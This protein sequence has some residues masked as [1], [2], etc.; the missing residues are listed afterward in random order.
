MRKSPVSKN[1]IIASNQY[2]IK[3]LSKSIIAGFKLL[4]KSV[5]IDHN[6]SKF[7]SGDDSFWLI[8][9]NTR[10]VDTLH[11][12]ISVKAATSHSVHDV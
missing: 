3:H 2:I 5:E 6:K 1:F 4:N 11:K 8:Q 12:R 7:H 10:V 9:S